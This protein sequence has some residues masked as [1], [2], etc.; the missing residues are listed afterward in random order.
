MK[1]KLESDRL[2]LRPINTADY[3][4]IKTL[5]NTEGWIKF[6]GDR[7]I[8][9][10]DDAKNYVRKIIDNRSV[11]YWVV[12]FK[13]TNIPIGVITLIKRDALEF[14]DLGFAFLPEFTKNGYAFEASGLI[15]DELKSTLSYPN[16]LAITIPEN[17]KSIA[18]LEKLGFI[19]NEE[20]I[21]EDESLL[22]YLKAI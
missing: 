7:K 10:D 20:T 13:N 6:I 4:F 2:Y 22:V 21:I 3:I 17:S 16:I 1:E 15:L 9:T 19:F 18:L 5:V 8:H 14:H 12:T 11:I